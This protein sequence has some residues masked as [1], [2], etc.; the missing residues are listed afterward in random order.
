MFCRLRNEPTE[1]SYTT[2]KPPY[3][4]DA[5]RGFNLLDGFYLVGIS[6]NPPLRHKEPEKL[7]GRDAEDALLRV[8]LEINLA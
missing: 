5:L 1:G 8:Q 2:C 3:V 4:L 6:F 7:A